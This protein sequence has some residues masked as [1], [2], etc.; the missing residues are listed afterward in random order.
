MIR[1]G[2]RRAA[3]AGVEHVVRLADGRALAY[4]EYGD[5][6]GR[7]VVS[8]HGGL[9]SGRDAAP[10]H[11]AALALGVRLISP[12]RPGIGASDPAPGRTAAGAAADLAGLLDALG[13]ARAAVIGWS[14]GGPYAIACAALAP[15]RVSA[16][17]VVAGAPPFDDAV[18]SRLN[19]A[20]RRLTRLSARRP[21]AA[22]LTFRTVGAL[23]RNAPRAW[24]RMTAR[25][26]VP[27]E[28]ALLGGRTGRALAA[29]A[30]HA[31]V[32]GT[33]MV[34]EYRAWARP[35]GAAAADVT[36][37]AV[38]WHGDR[39][40]LVAPA[41]GAELAGLIPGARLER[42]ADAGHFLAYAHPRDVLA[43]AA[44]P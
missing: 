12:D 6:E 8:H 15:A 27:A 3:E 28:A 40:R 31:L 33:G 30:G 4:R 16:L 5:P 26:A 37:P 17:V 32:G 29:A 9:V 1:G 20:D 43:S 19:A 41:W 34:E 18:A 36:V 35:W 22:G 44:G 14:M 24:S 38:V 11:E 13:V 25:G 23:A 7:P 42:R 2:G 10:L 39:D 21:R